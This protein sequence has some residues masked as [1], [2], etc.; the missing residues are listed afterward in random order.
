MPLKYILN[1]PAVVAPNEV[2][3]NCAISVG[4]NVKPPTV[5]DELNDSSSV[6]ASIR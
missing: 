1:V 3:S 4:A 2:A 5:T 6:S